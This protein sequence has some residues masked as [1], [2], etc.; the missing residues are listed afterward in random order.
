MDRRVTPP[1]QVTSPTWGPPS[2]CKRA[3]R[4]LIVHYYETREKKLKRW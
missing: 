1:K 3:L 4:L 2:P